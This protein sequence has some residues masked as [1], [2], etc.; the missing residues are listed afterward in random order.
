MKKI[1]LK[2]TIPCKKLK[3]RFLH[4]LYSKHFRMNNKKTTQT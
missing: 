3:I 2:T 1:E 4:F